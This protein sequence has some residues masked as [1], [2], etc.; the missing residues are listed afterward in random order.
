VADTIGE[1]GCD[2]FHLSSLLRAASHGVASLPRVG[3]P[4]PALVA[5]RTCCGV[6]DAA[7]SDGHDL[8]TVKLRQPSHEFTVGV[9]ISYI[10]YPLVLTPRYNKFTCACWFW[11]LV[12]MQGFSVESVGAECGPDTNQ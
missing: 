12:F 4:P 7:G 5:Y 8:L 9:G 2:Y 10:P 11:S 3:L 1:D 6:A